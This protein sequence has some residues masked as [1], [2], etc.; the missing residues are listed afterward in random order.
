[1]VFTSY[2]FTYAF[3]IF[4]VFK[5]ECF[6]KFKKKYPIKQKHTHFQLDFWTKKKQKKLILLMKRTKFCFLNFLSFVNRLSN[7]PKKNLMTNWQFCK[8]KAEVKR[9]KKM[10]LH[11]ISTGSFSGFFY[12]M[13]FLWDKKENFNQ[14]KLLLA[15]TFVNI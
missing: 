3:F 4:F 15:I 2:Q 8:F 11:L 10:K 9:R 6:Q 12:K 1:M 13:S 5:F 14:T 7:Y